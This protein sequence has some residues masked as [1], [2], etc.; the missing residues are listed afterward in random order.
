MIFYKS[1][2][3][4]KHYSYK[5]FT[6]FNISVP[7]SAVHTCFGHSLWQTMSLQLCVDQT[8]SVFQ[9]PVKPYARMLST[10]CLKETYIWVVIFTPMLFCYYYLFCHFVKVTNIQN[11]PSWEDT[12]LINLMLRFPLNWLLSDNRRYLL[13][14]FFGIIYRPKTSLS[15]LI[16]VWIIW[17]WIRSADL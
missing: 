5:A 1:K 3:A 4:R 10:K 13:S 16:I 15:L 12:L 7:F 9:S 17:Q 6:S 14:S 8:L 2:C 11:N